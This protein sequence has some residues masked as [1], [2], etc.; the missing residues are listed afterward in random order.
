M[1]ASGISWHGI[2]DT[3]D[4]VLQY[5][6]G[7]GGSHSADTICL[8]LGDRGVCGGGGS[9]DSKGSDSSGGGL[10]AAGPG[11]DGGANP[12]PPA[13]SGDSGGT[14]TFTVTHREAAPTSNSQLTPIYLLDVT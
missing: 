3:I 10:S 13:Q 8:T 2:V 6:F 1:D 12:P 7:F 14:P 9:S 11:L 4:R 5:M